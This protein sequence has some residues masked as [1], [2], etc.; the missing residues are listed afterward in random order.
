MMQGQILYPVNPI[1]LMPPVTAT[2]RTGCKEPMQHGQEN[3]SLHIK[4]KLPSLQKPFDDLFNPQLLSEPAKDQRGTNLSRR[5]MNLTL[6]GQNQKHFLGEPGEGSDE[7]LNI[8]F[9]P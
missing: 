8:P 4:L 1:I 9:G 3:G 6:A 5:G 7:L 2:V